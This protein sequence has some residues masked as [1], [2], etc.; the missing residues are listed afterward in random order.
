MCI[1]TARK[2]FFDMLVRQL[3][4]RIIVATRTDFLNSIF[5]HP[6]NDTLN[7]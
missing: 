1:V 2:D 3:V 6:R 5:N 4:D 7:A